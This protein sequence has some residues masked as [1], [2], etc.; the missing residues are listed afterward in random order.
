MREHRE[1]QIPA[2]PG[3]DPQRFFICYSRHDAGLVERI[4]TALETHGISCW[5]DKESIAGSKI[6]RR[7]VVEGIRSTEGVIFFASESSFHSKHVARELTVA[8]EESKR[9]LPVRLDDSEPVGEFILLLSG[10]QWVRYDAHNHDSDTAQI[11]RALSVTSET[12]PS[13]A[14]PP[15]FP[16][17][18]RTAHGKPTW[19]ISGWTVLAATAVIVALLAGL[20]VLQ[21]RWHAPGDSARTLPEPSTNQPASR[22]T[23]APLPIEPTPEPPSPVPVQV[24]PPEASPQPL[25]TNSV[26]VTPPPVPPNGKSEDTN[27]PPDS[28]ARTNPAVQ[29]PANTT[30]DRTDSPGAPQAPVA[31]PPAV[32][33]TKGPEPAYRLEDIR[34]QHTDP[35]HGTPKR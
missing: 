24:V 15:V 33:P 8:D 23:E 28:G 1:N 20:I 4:C 27:L 5:L 6:W 10:I 2:P 3:A 11:V 18:P 22:P 12:G 19:V 16:G 32:T 21:N 9:I 13:A 31:K 34:I 14:R 29:P 17:P 7:T 25:P 35:E 26:F 30:G